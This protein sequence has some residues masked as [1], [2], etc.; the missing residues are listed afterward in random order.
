MT[1]HT[2]NPVPIILVTPD[3]H[4]LRHTTLRA[5]GILSAVAPTVLQL[6]GVPVPADMT[7]PS[8]LVNS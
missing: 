8:L 6:L 7:T 3:E 4:P 5:D 1:A 2:T